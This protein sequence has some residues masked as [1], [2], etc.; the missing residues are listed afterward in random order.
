MCFTMANV[1]NQFCFIRLCSK[2]H[3]LPLIYILFLYIFSAKF[4]CNCM[5]ATLTFV[6][7]MNPKAHLSTAYCRVIFQLHMEYFICAYI[8]QDIVILYFYNG[9]CKTLFYTP[10]WLILLPYPIYRDK[11]AAGVMHCLIV[12][13]QLR[14]R[15]KC[16]YHV[17]VRV[18]VCVL[19]V[20][21]FLAEKKTKN[22]MHL[23]I[24]RI[25]I[26]IKIK[27]IFQYHCIIL[28]DILLMICKKWNII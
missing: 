17:S 24:W 8:L 20:W 15:K 12:F 22:W 23:D 16:I 3:A 28:I 2:A 13:L 6:A 11:K 4:L 18:C 27:T 26:K 5:F 1:I 21:F 10:S 25:K 9:S 7:K 14:L 19:G